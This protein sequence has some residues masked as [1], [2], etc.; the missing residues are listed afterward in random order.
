MLG[1]DIGENRDITAEQFSVS[2]GFV[3]DAF[4]QPLIRQ[5][6]TRVNI[7]ADKLGVHCRSNSDR[8]FGVVPQHV[9]AERQVE[10]TLNFAGDGRE[11]CDGVRWCTPRI[12]GNIS[13]VFE[14]PSINAGIRQ[15]PRIVHNPINNGIE[16]E[17]MIR[18]TRQRGHM[19]HAKD[20]LG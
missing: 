6:R 13:K 4:D 10:A 15:H 5:T 18:R 3:R 20:W 17:A 8:A 1:V 16:A 19:Q 2:K 12:K 14:N 7:Y 11:E 9:D